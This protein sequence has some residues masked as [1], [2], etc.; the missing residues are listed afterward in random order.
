MIKFFRKLRRQLI[1]E[2]NTT[3]YLK[4]AIGEIVLVVVGIL[5]ALS[6]N[7]WNHGRIEKI[8]ENKYYENLKAELA[9]DKIELYGSIK[10]NADDIEKLKY[11]IQIIEIKDRKSVDTLGHISMTLIRYSDAYLQNNLY[12][13]ILNSGEIKLVNNTK[14]IKGI[15]KLEETYLYIN[16]MEDIHRDVVLNKGADILMKNV[17]FTNSEIQHRD[18]LFT[19]EFQNLMYL[20]VRIMDEKNEIYNRALVEIQAINE[21]ID[22]ELNYQNH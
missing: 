9:E 4:Y 14:I 21:L 7:N 8:A 17:K 5:I 20:Y 6:I 15:R 18:E 19:F 13:T 16:K 12:N 1:K 22:E 3:N 10:Y 11:G 2:G